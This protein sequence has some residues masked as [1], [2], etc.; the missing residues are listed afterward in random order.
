[1]NN[2]IC[3]DYLTF[4]SKIHSYFY[5]VELLGLSECSFEERPGFYG[6]RNCLFFENIRIHYNGRDDMGICV[7]MSGKGLRAWEHYGNADYDKIFSLILEHYSDNAEK[8]EM[9]ITRLDVAYDDFQGLID[10]S[11]LLRETQ[12]LNFVSR[13]KDWQCI[14]GS[15]GSSVNH[16]STSSQVYIRIYDK[17][18]EQGRDDLEHWVRAELQLRKSCALGFIM[19][20][21]VVDV[22]YF[23]TLNNYL[24]YVVSTENVSNK[25]ML[26]TAPY[27]I[28]WLQSC[29]S[30]S[31]FY[32]PALTYNFDTLHNYVTEHMACS[33]STVVDVIGV[34]QFFKDIF[35]SRKGKK[36]NERYK[37]IKDKYEAHSDNILSFLQEHTS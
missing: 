11:L 15:K 16:G 3:Y 28:S 22:K 6:Y 20:K 7:E 37:S 13:F 27:W 26:P 1:M 8:R 21:S 35:R 14:C 30:Q 12:D 2:A 25:S 36:L 5:I 31:I 9:N 24:R 33:I 10:L 17:K 19:S 32:K 23:E 34:E 4:T 18:A 29:G